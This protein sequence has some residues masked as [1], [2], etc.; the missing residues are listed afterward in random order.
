MK[1]PLLVLL[2]MFITSSALAS[3]RII[4]GDTLNTHEVIKLDYNDEGRILIQSC[5]IQADECHELTSNKGLFNKDG[6]SLAN[7]KKASLRSYAMMATAGVAH[8]IIPASSA[9]AT[10]VAV[11]LL[12]SYVGI[13]VYT[14]SNIATAL[15][16][17]AAYANMKSIR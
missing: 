16:L 1:K 4:T 17:G 8:I 3:I 11:H 6:Y 10:Y 14:V 9:T 2:T 7:I 13:V 5:H 12:A 15:G